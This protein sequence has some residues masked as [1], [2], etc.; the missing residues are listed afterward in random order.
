MGLVGVLGR[1]SVVRCGL[2]SAYELSVSKNKNK[3]SHGVIRGGCWTA[4]L[5]ACGSRIQC[6]HH[7]V[8]YALTR[9]KGKP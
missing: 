5:G 9:L 7:V 1:V 8:R 2:N 4:L 6:R 3:N